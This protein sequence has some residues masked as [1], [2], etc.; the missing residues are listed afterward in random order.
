MIVPSAK[1]LSYFYQVAVS[2]SFSKAAAHLNTSQPSLSMAI[3]RLE[4]RLET[5]LFYRNKQGLTLTDAG[6][7]LFQSTRVLI[8]KWQSIKSE[9][10]TS[11]KQIS[12]HLT[13][14]APNVVAVFLTKI[15]S[16]LYIKHPGLT[17]HIKNISPSNGLEA[18]KNSSIDIS[19][20]LNANQSN[21]MVIEKVRDLDFAFWGK[22][23]LANNSL[24]KPEKLCI[25]CNPNLKPVQILLKQLHARQLQYKQL[26]EVDNLD[27]IA[28]LVMSDCGIGIL[29][30]CL[31]E[32]FYADKLSRI[33]TLPYSKN[34]INL[35][36]QAQST[37][38]ASIQAVIEEIKLLRTNY[39]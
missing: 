39:Q 26:R 18:I 17:I 33:N 38:L 28:E 1:E 15:L 30:S 4:Q 10:N 5:T 25:I 2:L 8:D 37:K 7:R 31:I 36:Y 16:S 6:L 29:P 19:I 27:T 34:Q 35:V 20:L 11:S 3:K 23:D 13:I 22:K 12:G 9:I 24:T 21:G 32:A 14:G